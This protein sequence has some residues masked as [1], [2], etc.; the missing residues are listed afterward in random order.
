MLQAG[1]HGSV[2]PLIAARA[3]T[4]QNLNELSCMDRLNP[5]FASDARAVLASLLKK[6][7][8]NF[9]GHGWSRAVAHWQTIDEELSMLAWHFW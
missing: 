2:D 7:A 4:S 5:V 3:P 9:G 6:Q 1:P 8:V